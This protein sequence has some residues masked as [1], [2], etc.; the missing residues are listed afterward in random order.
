[1]KIDKLIKEIKSAS[2]LLK[3][4]DKLLNYTVQ[5]LDLNEIDIDWNSIEMANT[6]FLGCDMTR[7]I[8]E[9]LRNKGALIF[10]KIMGLPYNPYRKNLYTWQKLIYNDHDLHIYNHFNDN[11]FNPS[12]TEALAQRIHDHAIDDAL[13]ELIGVDKTGM[14]S[15]KCVGIM[16]GHGAL[17]TDKTYKTVAITAQKLA[18]NGF[19]IMSGGGPGIMEAANLGAYM[20]EKTQ[21]QLEDA[22]NML[23]SIT[24]FNDANYTK[25]AETVLKKYPDGQ[26]NLSIPTWFYGHE[27]PNIFATHIAK[28][29]SN[30]LREDVLLSTSIYGIIYAPGS[31]GTVQE[32]FADAAQDHYA[33]YGYLSP[34][35][36]FGT[37]Y[38][39]EDIPIYSTLHK[40]AGN[41]SY[42]KMIGISDDSDQILDFIIKHPPVKA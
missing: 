13:R 35:V 7:E 14:T 30:A 20:G 34:M 27:P 4:K 10:P 18:K 5:S 2:E 26:E 28:Y 32:I 21:A 11:K 24:D 12:I 1:M 33:S 19:Y 17:R 39:T 41:K 16:G 37:K 15:K 9:I 42:N 22:I 25:L 36:F 29:F 38:W 23:A 6:T 8:E 31:A 40:L 3:Q